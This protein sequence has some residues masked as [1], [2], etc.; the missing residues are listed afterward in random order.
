MMKKNEFYGKYANVP[1]HQRTIPIDFNI[2]GNLNLNDVYAKM[3]KLDEKISFIEKEQQ[4]LM[5]ISEEAVLKLQAFPG[6]RK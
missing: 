6:Q 2:S 1:L 4:G 5:D 3:K